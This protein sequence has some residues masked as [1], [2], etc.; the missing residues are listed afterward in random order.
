MA[1]NAF[2]T[3]TLNP[4]A[5][6]TLYTAFTFSAAGIYRIKI[7]RYYLP[8]NY[9]L[10]LSF[11]QYD[12]SSKV[13]LYE[14]SDGHWD[15]FNLSAPPAQPANGFGPLWESP[16]DLSVPYGGVLIYQII[17]LNGATFAALTTA[18]NGIVEQ[19]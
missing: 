16:F 1:Y 11:Q 14:M 17:M 3:F 18:L 15:I 12:T 9:L 10:D 7:N 5:A 19:A 8:V 6:S 13:N 2:G 4:A